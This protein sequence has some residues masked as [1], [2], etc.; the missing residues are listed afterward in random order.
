MSLARFPIPT[1]GT[2]MPRKCS[3][4]L[5]T[6][7]EDEHTHLPLGA[8]AGRADVR[9]KEALSHQ[10]CVGVIVEVVDGGG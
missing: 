8:R 6:R 5:G 9:A 2:S 10:L 4:M 1:V 7:S 3:V